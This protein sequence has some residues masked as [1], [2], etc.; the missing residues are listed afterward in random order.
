MYKLWGHS[1]LNELSVVVRN[2]RRKV[3]GLP[4][5]L[6]LSESFPS[7]STGLSVV[8]VVH[9][10]PM[11]SQRRVTTLIHRD[12]STVVIPWNHRQRP[13][14]TVGE[15]PLRHPT[16]AWLTSLSL[17]EILNR[18]SRDRGQ[19]CLLLGHK[20]WLWSTGE[21]PSER[22]V[23]IDSGGPYLHTGPMGSTRTT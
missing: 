9:S 17:S 2:V 19:M 11:W 5:T 8:T 12:V 7:F 10:S 22:S 4:T 18:T 3:R 20:H 1:K 15:G 13:S 14:C 6:T 23:E 16:V 21:G